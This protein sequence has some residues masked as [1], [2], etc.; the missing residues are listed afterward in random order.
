MSQSTAKSKQPNIS[1]FFKPKPPSSAPGPAPTPTAKSPPLTIRPLP[2]TPAP[3]A[4]SL[5][6]PKPRT[7]PPPM[8]TPLSGIRSTSPHDSPPSSSSITSPLSST[9]PL[10]PSSLSELAALT[11][12]SPPSEP[13]GRKRKPVNYAEPSDDPFD[14]DEPIVAPAA[15]K[16]GRRISDDEEDYQPTADAVADADDDAD[17]DAAM[18]VDAGEGEEEEKE[19]RKAR[20]PIRRS[21]SVEAPAASHV[22]PRSLSFPA[23]AQAARVSDK[24]REAVLW[25]DLTKDPDAA[26]TKKATDVTSEKVWDGSFLEEDKRMDA[27]GRKVGHPQYDPTTLHV[28]PAIYKALTP[29]QK[30]YFDIKCRHFDLLLFYKIGKFYELYDLDAEVGVKEFGLTY[31]VNQS[32]PHAGFPEAAFDK[33]SIMAVKNGHRIGRVEQTQTPKELEKANQANKGKAK[34]SH[35][36]ERTLCSVLT[37]GTLT[38]VDHI[39]SFHSASLFALIERE[40]TPIEIEQLS[41]AGTRTALGGE[42]V[43]EYGV[44]WV[45]CST[46]SF[47]IGQF[48]DD[49]PRSQLATLLATVT[50]REVV[51]QHNNLSDNSFIILRNELSPQCYQQLIVLKSVDF[52]SAEK[53]YEFLQDG[54]YFKAIRPKPGDDEIPLEQ[55]EDDWPQVLLELTESKKDL[56]FHALG[57]LIHMLVYT[58]NDVHLL[59]AKDFTLYNPTAG[60]LHAKRLILDTSTLTNLGQTCRAQRCT[61]FPQPQQLCSPCY[62]PCVRVCRGDAGQ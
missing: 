26:T 43:C 34:A 46:G 21:A 45:D 61:P 57:G 17:E 39:A 52:M 12:P 13:A 58:K 22:Q 20:P 10:T 25:A 37:P 4:A 44:C 3:A 8:S 41:Q 28:P 36:V 62:F 19:E 14:E 51:T 11:P 53:T 30:Q 42:A 16:R 56:A 1:S 5:L 60:G 40:L 23:S 7:K 48:Y 59:S 47:T 55:A 50:P 27:K 15:R 49:T 6:S 29:A 18:D 2:S 9:I 35:I 54:A 32:R 38:D 31:M 33:Y 24:V